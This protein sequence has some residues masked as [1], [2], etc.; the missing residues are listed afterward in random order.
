MSAPAVTIVIPTQG[1]RPSLVPAL[2]SALAQDFTPLEVVVVDDAVGGADWKTE[3]AVARLL[4]DNRVRIVPFHQGRGC[5]AAK[6]AGWNAARGEWICYLDDDNEYRPGKVSAQHEL[7]MRSRSPVVLCG[8]EFRAAGRRRFRQ[9]GVARFSGDGLLLE[10]LADT[11]VLFHRNTNAPRWD[12]SLGTVDD[13]CL[14]QALI[15]HHGLKSVPNVPAPLAIYHVHGGERAN[16]G[17]QRLYAGQ[18]RLLV[19]WSRGYSPRARRTLLLRMLVAFCKFRPGHWGRLA[20]QGR[21]LVAI[22]GWREWRY[23]ANASGAKVP[24]LRRWMVR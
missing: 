20:T 23:V 7:A 10:A 11:N 12:E 16:L 24:F 2:A 1:R 19:R 22:G 9:I 8:V 6:N 21:R 15:A 18:R 3:P 17:F 14:F 13:A 5:A 4:A